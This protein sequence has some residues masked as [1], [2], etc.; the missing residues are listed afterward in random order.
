MMIDLERADREHAAT[1]ARQLLELGEKLREGSEGPY[2]RAIAGFCQYASGGTADA[3][4]EG[5][6]ELRIVDAKHRLAYTLIKVAQMEADQ[7]LNEQAARRATEAL[8]YATLL[9]RATEMAL[10]RHILARTCRAASDKTAAR[11][12]EEALLELLD[13]GIAVWARNYI[14]APQRAQ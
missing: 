11:V 6:Q 12:H 9:R 1:R 2:S 8:E 10:A 5:L 3:L 14:E 13:A 7:G 4:E